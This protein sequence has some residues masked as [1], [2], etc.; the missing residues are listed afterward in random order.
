MLKRIYEVGFS[1]TLQG[2]SLSGV[3]VHEDDK[4][5]RLLSNPLDEGEKPKELA[6]AD[7]D[8][9]VESPVSLMPLGLLNTLTQEDILDLLAF[10]ESGGNSA[11]RAF[12]Q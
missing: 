10:L 9:R 3:V 4:V 6:K 1:P 12:R 11:Y 7:I 2:V 5:I 8:E